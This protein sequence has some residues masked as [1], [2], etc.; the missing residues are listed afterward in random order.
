MNKIK[1]FF[2]KTILKLSSNNIF[3]FTTN[4]RPSAQTKSSISPAAEKLIELF[5]PSSQWRW[6]HHVLMRKRY[7]QPVC[8]ARYTA[9][10]V[11][12]ITSPLRTRPW[13]KA[14]SAFLDEFFSIAFGL[15][16]KDTGGNSQ[17]P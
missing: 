4:S 8:A 10:P 15:A 1:E 6:P 14:K 9:T 11:I 16:Q 7:Y 17:L 12:L 13:N 2:I 3:P 5:A